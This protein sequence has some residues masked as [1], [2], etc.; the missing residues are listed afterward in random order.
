VRKRGGKGLEAGGGVRRECEYYE[1]KR[2]VL[3]LISPFWTGGWKYEL[4][5]EENV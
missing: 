2:K 4:S 5:H 3:K 1:K